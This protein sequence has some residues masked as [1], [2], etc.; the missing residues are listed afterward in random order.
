[1]S[2]EIE[3]I[4]FFFP[5]PYISGIPVLFSNIANY[6]A[7]K[8][9]ITINII[10]YENGALKLSCL[11]HRRINF[12]VFNDFEACKIDYKTCL[13]IQAGIPYK[14]R[15]EL[16]IGPEV[17]IIQ[18]AAHE[19]NLVPFIFKL[20]FFRN[21]QERYHWMYLAVCLLNYH[22]YKILSKWVLKMINQGAI[23]FMTECIYKT[24]KN[25]LKFKQPDRI[26]YMPNLSDGKNAYDEQSIILKSKEIS[27][28]LHICWVGRIAD[29]K[30]HI[31]N[32]SIQSIS[33]LALK[34]KKHIC[35]HIIG[36]GE[37]LKELNLN[38][39]NDFFKLKNVGKL[40]KS[41]VDYYLQKHIHCLFS[42]GTSALDGARIGLP[43]VLLDQSYIPIKPGYK[44]RYL[45]TV[46]G[47]DLGHPINKDDFEEGN[48]TLQVIIEELISDYR[49]VSNR[50]LEH[51]NE[52]HTIQIVTEKLLKQF[53]ENYYRINEV[54]V[55]LLKQGIGRKI[56][57]YYKK[58]IKKN[59]Y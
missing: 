5:Y 11:K 40:E 3:N 32:Y 22:K 29:F 34:I 27:E 38:C 7:Q 26:T 39:A 12:I 52:N 51:F 47:F 53:D 58:N 13:I 57:Y 55:E 45:N 28:I 19:Y 37:Y 20:K 24:T 21:L 42:M 44:F 15:S 30:V 6:L 8:D 35:F 50:C 41:E 33:K 18:W 10:D 4:T 43:V 56:Y 49:K 14:L 36:E 1:M 16:K 54:P 9:N 31:L 25:H 59:F 2:E 48:N 23:V 46:T 17:K